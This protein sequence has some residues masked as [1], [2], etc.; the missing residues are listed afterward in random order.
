MSPR[1]LKLVL[2]AL[3]SASACATTN[4]T[5]SN[6]EEEFV[7]P[8]QEFQEDGFRKV[9]LDVNDDQKA[10]IVNYYRAGEG[11]EQTLLVRKEIDLDFRGGADVIQ[12]W[13]SGEMTREEIDAD[14]DGKIDWKDYY[15]GGKRI[16]AEWDTRYDGKADLVRYYKEGAVARVE[17]DTN[18]DGAVDY[19]EYYE[20]GVMQRSGWDTDKDGKI[21]KWDER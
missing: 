7:D 20:G 21:D 2:A 8:V 15:S 3:L 9:T 18:D 10:D 13:E 6:K 17:M 1:S 4:S 5:K 16:K 11:D 19:W 12:I 14:F